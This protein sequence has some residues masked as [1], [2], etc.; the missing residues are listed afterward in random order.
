MRRVLDHLE[1]L[2]VVA[3]QQRT[4]AERIARLEEG[5]KQ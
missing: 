4:G 3:E 2:E 5:V 1:V